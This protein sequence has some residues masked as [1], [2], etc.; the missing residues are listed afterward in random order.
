MELKENSNK[1]M[2]VVDS[3]KNIPKMPSYIEWVEVVSSYK[4]FCEFI[5]KFFDAHKELPK[6]ITI[7]H[8][9]SDEHIMLE[10]RRPTH[11]DIEYNM[12]KD[13]GHGLNCAAW[14][15]DFANKHNLYLNRVTVHG[16]NNK[17]SANIIRCIDSYYKSKDDPQRCFKINLNYD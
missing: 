4:E 1:I 11:M 8:D 15:C 10:L 7:N 3:N 12:Y 13:T 14:L 9:L 5:Q 17:G 16:L 2:L 6:L